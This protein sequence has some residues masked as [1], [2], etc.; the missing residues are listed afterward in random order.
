VNE[1]ETDGMV[2]AKSINDPA[3]L[4]RREQ[5]NDEA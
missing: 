4:N 3:I 2:F 1:N 5:L